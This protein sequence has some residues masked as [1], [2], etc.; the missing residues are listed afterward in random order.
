[1]QKND[2]DPIQSKISEGM[3]IFYEPVG[4]LKKI[5]ILKKVVVLY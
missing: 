2:L 4:I 3:K 5:Q 1:M